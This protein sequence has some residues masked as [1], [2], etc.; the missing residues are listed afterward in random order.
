MRWGG[1]R[2]GISLADPSADWRLSG[3]C[4]WPAS[5]AGWKALSPGGGSGVGRLA[6]SS[7]G[8]HRDDVADGDRPFRP[9]GGNA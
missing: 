6:Q 4:C 8:R 9:V 5:G 3:S 7:G 1:P 2:R